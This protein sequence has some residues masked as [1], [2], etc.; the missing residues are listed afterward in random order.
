MIPFYF[1]F[2]KNFLY[3][4]C[5]IVFFDSEKE[6]LLGNGFIHKISILMFKNQ[7]YETIFVYFSFFVSWLIIL[8]YFN[9][10]FKEY[11]ILGYLLFLPIFIWPIFQEYFDPLILILAFTFFSSKVY[12]NYKN[13]IIL[14]AY[15]SIFLVSSNIY[16]LVWVN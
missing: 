11:L 8:I 3:L 5:L 2:F 10:D 13:S 16:Y 15:L 14:F 1:I 6:S 7:L 4:T 9:K 12:I